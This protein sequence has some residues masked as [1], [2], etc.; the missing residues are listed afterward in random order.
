MC[1]WSTFQMFVSSINVL[2]CLGPV[3]QHYLSVLCDIDERGTALLCGQA[4]CK[5]ASC[6]ARLARGKVFLMDRSREKKI[7]PKEYHSPSNQQD[8]LQ[9]VH[10]RYR[11]WSFTLYRTVPY[12]TVLAKNQNNNRVVF[13]TVLFC[14]SL[15]LGFSWEEDSVRFHLKIIAE[16]S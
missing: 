2:L 3:G 16:G 11:I 4:R 5:T 8:R 15:C 13:Q 6:T 10:Y 14:F 12:R 1:S 9:F 7:D